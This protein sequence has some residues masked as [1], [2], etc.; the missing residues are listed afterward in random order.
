MNLVSVGQM[1][2]LGLQVRFNHDGCFVEDL[3]NQCRLVTKGKINGRMFT[4][5]ADISE[6]Y[7]AMFAH[8]RGVIVN[9]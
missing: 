2:E 1:V 7:A 3:K 5:D 6:V 4:L 9:E 8:G